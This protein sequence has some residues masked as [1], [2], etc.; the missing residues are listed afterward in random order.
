[1]RSFDFVLEIVKNEIASLKRYNEFTMRNPYDM[2]TNIAH[3]AG[4]LRSSDIPE[5]TQE[6]VHNF[7]H[8][9]EDKFDQVLGFYFGTESYEGRLQYHIDNGDLPKY[10]EANIRAISDYMSS[11]N[12]H[13]VYFIRPIAYAPYVENCHSR[14][15]DTDL[16]MFT[17]RLVRNIVGHERRHWMQHYW[18]DDR[19]LNLHCDGPDT[20]ADTA[21][22]QDANWFAHIFNRHWFGDQV[23]DFDTKE[24][25]Y[26]EGK[27]RYNRILH[28]ARSSGQYL[29]GQILQ[30][31]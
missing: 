5:P 22:E 4:L 8:Y 20:P 21:E 9:F 30:G 7:V 1:M 14:L 16:V 18:E 24:V 6:Q 25:I 17:R 10:G 3:A 12:N 31:R 29:V 27:R 19:R 28:D 15:R 23:M 26:V 2:L 13:I 11:H